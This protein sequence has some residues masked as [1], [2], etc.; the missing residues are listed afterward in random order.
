MVAVNVW[1]TFEDAG[2]NS[3]EWI[4]ITQETSD[5]QHA[6]YQVVHKRFHREVARI[7]NMLLTTDRICECGNSGGKDSYVVTLI[8]LE[9]YRIAKL[10]AK[11]VGKEF[12]KPLVINT[13]DTL[14]EELP[15][16]FYCDY[17]I[18]KIEQYAQDN[19]IY[20]IYNRVAPSKLS[21]FVMRYLGARKFFTNATRTA[22]CTDYFKLTPLR[23]RQKIT[24]D[25]FPEYKLCS[26]SG[27]RV[28]ESV[29]RSSNMSKQR[30]DKRTIAEVINSDKHNISYAPI[31][32]WDADDVF[33]LLRLT[34][35]DPLVKVPT[36]DPIPSFM[37]NAGLLIEIYGDASAPDT[38]QINLSDG[39][40]EMTGGCGSSNASRTGCTFCTI[41]SSN[42]S[43]EGFISKTRWKALGMDNALRIR[44]YIWRLSITPSSRAFH[45]RSIDSV[46]QR[47]MLQQNVLKPK[48]TERVYRYLCQL[49]RD[50][51]DVQYQVLANGV[52]SFS[53]YLDILNDNTINPKAKQEYL[54]MYAQG[55]RKPF[56]QFVTKEDSILL[57]F[58]WA[59]DGLCTL[60]YAPIGIFDEVFE[61]NKTVP[62]PKLNSE[63]DKPPV[64]KSTPMHDAFALPLLSEKEENEY[65]FEPLE[66]WMP[67]HD[68]WL[69]SVELLCPSSVIQPK[70]ALKLIVEY[71][72][73]H[74]IEIQ[75]VS[76]SGSTK[77]Y[78]LVRFEAIHQQLIDACKEHQLNSHSFAHSYKTVVELRHIEVAEV[79]GHANPTPRAKTE[80]HYKESSIRVRKNG[81]PTTTR[82]RFYKPRVTSAL[83]DQFGTSTSVLMHNP[84]N[85]HGIELNINEPINDDALPI[86]RIS[87]DSDVGILYWFELDGWERAVK[88]YQQDKVE[89]YQNL[90]RWKRNKR[91]SGLNVVRQMMA[92]CGITVAER[93]KSELKR[94]IYRTYVLQQALAFDYQSLS[95]SQLQR[96]ADKGELISMRQ[97]RAD[98]ARKLLKLRAIRNEDRA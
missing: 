37:R 61:K 21:S 11:R 72:A 2:A 82:L 62:Y 42:K 6:R 30:T 76:I 78:P 7:A 34:G 55:I 94:L 19:G 68:S 56:Y 67:Y 65:R 98:K 25:R 58:I 24:R 45:A 85:K 31:R 44:D 83:R 17:T 50:A 52:T 71:T 66:K 4:D 49:T 16:K 15:V 29:R 64:L 12:I 32:S 53:G 63:F 84:S 57:S 79:V 51:D 41:V 27:V 91:Y 9:A 43:A 75:S 22:D 93:Y 92:Y 8:V 74:K 54:E 97:H 14:M 87:L 28:S 26:L 77:K 46:L 35:S 88:Q 13:I 90:K 73:D 36:L 70:H 80:R 69:Q 89:Q 18:P 23:A 1:D 86:D 81:V 10:R 38:C 47:V 33:A 40:D 60:D 3:L 48:L 20:L 95:L 96:R 59:L 39:G 5:E